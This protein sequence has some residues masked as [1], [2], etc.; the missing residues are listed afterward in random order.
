MAEDAAS[1][2]HLLQQSVT[3]KKLT[4]VSLLPFHRENISL[5]ILFLSRFLC[6]ERSSIILSVVYKITTAVPGQCRYKRG[7]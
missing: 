5:K 4:H 1:A 3:V 6:S 7:V 2:T